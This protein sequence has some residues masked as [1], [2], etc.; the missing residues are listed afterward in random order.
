ML[1]IN[2]SSMEEMG[3]FQ[4]VQLGNYWDLLAQ[5]LIDFGEDKAVLPLDAYLRTKKDEQFDRIIAKAGVIN[6]IAGLKW[7]S[8][9]P[10]N[11]TKGIPRANGLLILNDI[12]TGLAYAILDAVPISNIRTAGVSMLFLRE[13]CPTFERAV[14]FGTGIHGREHLRQLLYG[15][16]AGVFP[17][18]E[19]ILLYDLHVEAAEKMKSEYAVPL[20]V[21]TDVKDCFQ[22]NTAVIFC[23][24]ALKPYIGLSH[25]EGRKGLSMV[26]MSLRDFLP[27][28]LPFFDFC[29]AD[30]AQHVARAS[31]TVDLAVQDGFLDLSDCLELPDLLVRKRGN[32]FSP[33]PQG[34]NVIFNPMGLGS[35][36]LILGRY[37]YELAKAKEIGTDLVV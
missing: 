37:V 18:L 24:N 25:L 34:S 19:E 1:Y 23:T 31:T 15:K 32:Q 27:E 12:V 14:I 6:D 4:D 10:L 3:V 11:T 22:D 26:H 21:I 35:H 5:G 28:T 7:I 8:S 9:A 17:N 30:S 2:Q 36:D 13:F 20:G 16:E 33:F 29:V